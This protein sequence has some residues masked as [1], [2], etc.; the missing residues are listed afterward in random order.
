MAAD[1]ERGVS[2]FPQPPAV[3][4]KQYTDENVEA[5]RAPPPPPPIKGNYSMFGA[6]F[7]VRSTFIAVC[8]NFSAPANVIFHY[9]CI[10][11]DAN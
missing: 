2:P 4:Y 1:E 10:L 5:G 11:A 3:F 9:T 7:D 8:R 6:N